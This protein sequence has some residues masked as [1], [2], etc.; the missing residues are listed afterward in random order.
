MS[1]PI[2]APTVPA[3]SSMT[4]TVILTAISPTRMTNSYRTSQIVG[5]TVVNE[6]KD[7]VGTIDDLIISPNEKSAFAVLSVGGFL[8]IGAKYV[9]VPFS[10]LEAQA[11]NSHLLLRGATE[12]SLKNLP[13]YKY[14][15]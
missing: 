9:V 12:A 3:T 8:G 11:D 1:S 7:T 13:E 6:A 14:N 4:P 10:S 5:S 2:I 15:A